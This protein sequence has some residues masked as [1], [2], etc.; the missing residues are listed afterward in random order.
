MMLLTCWG[1]KGV[2]LRREMIRKYHLTSEGHLNVYVGMYN[3]YKLKCSD[4]HNPFYDIV[5]T[6]KTVLSLKGPMVGT[7]FEKRVKCEV[8]WVFA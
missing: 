2:G 6:E 4:F 8:W 3:T 7:L 1:V 5:G